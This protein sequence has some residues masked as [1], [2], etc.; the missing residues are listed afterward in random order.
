MK[1][2][3]TYAAMIQNAC[4]I[5]KADNKKQALEVLKK[6]DSSLRIKDVYIY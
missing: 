1:T 5:V 4:A 3:K 6:A 2:K